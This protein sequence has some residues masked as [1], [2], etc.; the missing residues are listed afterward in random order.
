M[1]G[2]LLRWLS[3]NRDNTS[4]SCYLS[5]GDTCETLNGSRGADTLIRGTGRHAADYPDATAGGKGAIYRCIVTMPY[6]MERAPESAIKQSA[7]DRVE[8]SCLLVV[9]PKPQ[10]ES[11]LLPPLVNTGLPFSRLRRFPD[12]AIAA[13][14]LI[15][16]WRAAAGD[17]LTRR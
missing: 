9:A 12:P 15:T 10:V 2:L 1:A 11:R 5:E 4:N 16:A 7:E 3:A 17:G 8:L 14:D 6:T 13:R